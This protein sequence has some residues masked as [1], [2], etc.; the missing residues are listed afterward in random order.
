MIKTINFIE[1]LNRVND[2]LKTK[3][4]LWIVGLA[5]VMISSVDG[6]CADKAVYDAHGKRDPFVPLVTMSTRE[7]SGLVG[8]EGVD[9]I[10]IEGIVY[11][12]KGSVIIVNGA[13]MKEG[14][15][16]GNIKVLKIESKGARFLLN[17]TEAYIALYTEEPK[18]KA[19]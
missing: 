12:P 5:F 14:D 6:L 4:F 7:S 9:D 15:E 17:G 10:A 11:D 18:G 3:F 16:L 8:V 13:V 19:N 1:F 2:N